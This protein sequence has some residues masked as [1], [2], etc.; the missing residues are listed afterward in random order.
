MA[1]FP[2]F[3]LS[4]VRL[5]G[6][7][8][9]I[10]LVY[11]VAGALVLAL[12][13]RA[14]FAVML[15]LPLAYWALMSWVP[16]PGFGA[17]DLSPEGNLAAWL[18][19]L[20]LGVHMWSGGG[21]VYDPEGLL[22]TLPAISTT[23]AGL[24]TGDFLR[25]ERELGPRFA[26]SLRLALGGAALVAAGLLWD[27]VFPINKPLWTSSYVAWTAGWALLTL[28]ALYWLVEVRGLHRWTRPLV[29]Y[30]MNAITVFV[31]SGL[32]AKTLILW[33]VPRPAGLRGDHVCI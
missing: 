22:S 5:V 19:R 23:L 11:L 12:S 26:T 8:A 30:G 9:R 2:G 16:V 3:D 27:L 33:R 32:L 6:V 18:D 4:T 31:A 14:V 17:G 28:A 10:A 7:L 15:G 29:I 25:S 20:V 1:A 21:G 13:R 24:F